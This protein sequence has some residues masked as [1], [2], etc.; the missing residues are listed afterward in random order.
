MLVLGA[1]DGGGDDN[2]IDYY[3]YP[4]TDETKETALGVFYVDCARRDK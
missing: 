2:N 3:T 4:K 1:V